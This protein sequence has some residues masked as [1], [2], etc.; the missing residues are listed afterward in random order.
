MDARVIEWSFNCD[1][2]S[3]SAKEVFDEVIGRH[4]PLVDIDAEWEELYNQLS[5]L[6]EPCVLTV[7]R[8]AHQQNP[9]LDLFIANLVKRIKK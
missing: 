3:E 9:R 4:G 6:R 1:E 7:S 5:D 8:P 2:A